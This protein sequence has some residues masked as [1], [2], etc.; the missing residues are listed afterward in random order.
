MLKEIISTVETAT[1][2]TAYPL[3]TVFKDDCIVYTYSPI[4]D[5][6]AVAR[7]RIELRIITK[8]IDKS[9]VYRKQIISALVPSADNMKINGMY[10]CQLNGGGQLRDAGT[11]TIHTILYFDYITKSDNN[12]FY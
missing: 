8:T 10:S 3:K 12:S 9:E 11:E 5:D 1:S 4:S 2:L 6:G 7:H